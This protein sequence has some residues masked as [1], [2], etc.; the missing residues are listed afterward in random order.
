MA[1][2]GLFADACSDSNVPVHGRGSAKPAEPHAATSA[3]KTL[4]G[5]VHELARR[6]LS[7]VERNGRCGFND[8]RV[9]SDK[10]VSFKALDLTAPCYFILWQTP[11]PISTSAATAVSDG[12]AVGAKGELMAWRYPSAHEHTVVVVIG[13][14]MT[15]PTQPDPFDGTAGSPGARCA[16]SMQA[17]LIPRESDAPVK[18]SA[19]V[20]DMGHICAESGMGEKTFWRFAHP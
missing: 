5:A 19:K 16:N 20:A 14:R 6:R 13:D 15:A 2:V 9:Y 11:P 1:A 12:V 10:N 4:P 3:L 17:L 7:V 8:E 18:L